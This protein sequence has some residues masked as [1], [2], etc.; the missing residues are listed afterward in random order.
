M[1]ARHDKSAASHDPEPV[2]VVE[3]IPDRSN[4]RSAWKY[5]LLAAIF[6]LWLAFLVYCQLA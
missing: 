5:F 4:R 3:G 6:L 1:T 2:D